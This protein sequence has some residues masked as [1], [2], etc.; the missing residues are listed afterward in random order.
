MQKLTLIGNLGADA[1]IRQSPGKDD[2]LSFKV[3]CTESFT[4]NS[5][6]KTER[7]TWYDCTS[8]KTHLAQFLKKGH[9]LH[10]EGYPKYEIYKS[11]AGDVQIQISVN[12][13]DIQLLNNKKD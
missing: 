1:V 2:F 3:A 6:D 10:V 5:G 12:V 13:R 4:N 8:K 7:T 11:G 9:Q